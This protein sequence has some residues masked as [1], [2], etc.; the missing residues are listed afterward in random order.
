[1]RAGKQQ[2]GGARLESGQHVGVRLQQPVA[3]GRQQQRLAG[4]QPHR[5]A[6][7]PQGS[8]AGSG[9]LLAPSAVAISTSTSATRSGAMAPCLARYRPASSAR[10]PACSP[11]PGRGR[12]QQALAAPRRWERLP[13]PLQ[14]PPPP[15]QPPLQPMSPPPGWEPG[16]WSAA[17]AAGPS[18]SCARGGSSWNADR[19]QAGSASCVASAVSGCRH[20]YGAR[21]SRRQLDSLCCCATGVY[22]WPPPSPPPAAGTY[23]QEAPD[24]PVSQ[25]KRVMGFTSASYTCLSSSLQV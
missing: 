16:H 25:R 3:P 12:C 13:P 23:S 10:C 6:L 4:Q 11:P 24:R 2:R 9:V 17:A 19:L 18:C 21:A 20:R 22:P 8:L 14:P 1:M 5:P 7:H 15:L